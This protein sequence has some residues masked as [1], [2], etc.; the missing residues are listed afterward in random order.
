MCALRFGSGRNKGWLPGMR[1]RSGSPAQSGQD[2]DPT[3][4]NGPDP[5]PNYKIGTGTDKKVLILKWQQIST[6]PV[7]I[8]NRRDSAED[9]FVNN[10]ELFVFR[11]N[12]MNT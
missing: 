6:V 7:P 10:S 5:D 9:L 2:W 12:V 3:I 4:M 11:S 1:V 8:E